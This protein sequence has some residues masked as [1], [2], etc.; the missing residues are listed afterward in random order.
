MPSTYFDNFP[1]IG[2]SLN[3]AGQP[4][5]Q[6]WVVDI[7]RRSAPIQSL[8]TNTTTYYQYL[9]GEGDTPELIA[10][11]QY[12]SAKYFWVVTMMNNIIDPLIQW[13]KDY[14]NFVRYIIDT[15]GSVAAASGTNHHF[16]MSE[17]KTDSFG[18]ASTTTFVIDQTMYNTLYGQVTPVVTTFPGGGTVTTTVTVAAVDNYTYELG[19]N[20]AKRPIILLHPSYLPQ[21]VKELEG[22]LA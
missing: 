6:Q 3:P 22:L 2:Y 11:K 16:T 13:P 17:V 21:V 12:G 5:E 15:Y 7:F 19:L 14:A 1:Y 18:N 20:D 10:F 9:I 8:L 4:G